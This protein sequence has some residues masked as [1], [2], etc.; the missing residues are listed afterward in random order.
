MAKMMLARNVCP[1]CGT[2]QGAAPLV[3][4][5]CGAHLRDQVNTIPP[6]G[7]PWFVWFPLNR[8]RYRGWVENTTLGL[9]MVFGDATEP[10]RPKDNLYS[11]R[12]RHDDEASEWADKQNE[13]DGVRGRPL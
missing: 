12:T 10:S 8:D 6:I 11:N 3:C 9:K 13:K 1:V 4:G 7:A 2:K 5:E